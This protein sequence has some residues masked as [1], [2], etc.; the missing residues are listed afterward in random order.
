MSAIQVAELPDNA[1]LQHY[2]LTGA[3]TDCYCMDLPQDISLAEYIEAFYTSTVFK[4]ERQ[5]LALLA[6]KPAS[7]LTARQL[8]Q[9]QAIHFSAWRVEGRSADQLL[10]CD[11]WGRTRSWLMVTP[12]NLAPSGSTRLYFG[13]AVLPQSVSASGQ[14][15]FGIGFHA[16]SGFHRLYT[17]ALM[18]SAQSRLRMTPRKQPK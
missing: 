13:S 3:F 6:G 14:A 8:A 16:L 15:S 7:D 18:R 5:I 2:V 17:R 10:L 11:M 1:L 9:E 4:V 12:S